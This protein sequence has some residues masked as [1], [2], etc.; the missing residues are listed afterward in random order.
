MRRLLWIGDAVCSSGFAKVTHRIVRELTRTWECYVL[1]L[2][3]LGDP[4]D[5]PFKVYPAWPGGDAFGIKRTPHLVSAVK[6]DLV[7]VLNDPWNVPQYVAGCGSVPVVAITPVDGKNCRG[8]GLNGTAH[9]IFWTEFGRTEAMKGGYTG[10]SSVIPLGVDLRTYSPFDKKLARAM[11]Q[12]PAEVA[13]G[14]IIGAVGRNQP[15][16]RLDLTVQYFCEWIKD[17]G[18]DDAFLFLH[19]APTGDAGYDLSHLMTHYFGVKK[20]LILSEPPVGFG[21]TRE[22]LREVYSCFDAQVTTTQGEGWGLCTLEGMACGVPQIV[23]DWSALGE[24]TAGAAVRIRCDD[25]C[26]TP[27][28]INAVGGIANR[29]AFVEALDSLYRNEE[30]RRVISAN[31]LSL[32]RR[33]EFRWETIAA[34]TDEVLSGVLERTTRKTA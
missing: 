19:V 33:P 13:D 14:F 30:T 34:R 18:V 21:E 10:E 31:G 28:S 32:A 23:P 20:R 9:T 29:R 25:I 24:W 27:N 6:P 26:V 4:H 12:L 3:Y 8:D 22:E 1:G 15:R 7:V 17:Y 2:N 5:L 11:L 16:K